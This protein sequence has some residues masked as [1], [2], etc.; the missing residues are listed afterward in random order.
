[1]NKH[2]KTRD[3]LGRPIPTG[4]GGA[5]PGNGRKSKAEEFGLARLLEDCWTYEQRKEVITKLHEYALSGSKSG[6]SAASLLLAY[7]YGKP[8]EHV[9]VETVDPKKIAIETIWTIVNE[10]GLSEEEARTIVSKRFGISESDLIS[11]E[12]M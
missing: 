1:V 9:K 4:F 12:V 8:T 2:A 11:S 3:S 6:V 7:A 5:V 10:T